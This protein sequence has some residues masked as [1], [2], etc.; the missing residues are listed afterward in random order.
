MGDQY[1]GGVVGKV[2]KS[3]RYD[4]AADNRG[5]DVGEHFFFVIYLVASLVSWVS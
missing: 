2:A 5:R 4:R 1:D 3:G